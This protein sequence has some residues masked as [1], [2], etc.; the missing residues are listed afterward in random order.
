[1]TLSNAKTLLIYTF[2]SALIKI[3]MY[4]FILP[5]DESCVACTS[6]ELGMSREPRVTQSTRNVT[7]NGAVC[8]K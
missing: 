2:K 3:F 5:I 4:K 7:F 8:A 6:D 1:M